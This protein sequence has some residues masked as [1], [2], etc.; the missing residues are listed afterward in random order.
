MKF[1]LLDE[2][3][4]S[5]YNDNGL[6]LDEKIPVILKILR[7]DFLGWIL[8]K[9]LEIVSS[10]NI[11]NVVIYVV[12]YTVNHRRLRVYYN[13][14]T[15]FKSYDGN[16]L[17]TY[18]IVDDVDVMALYDG[19]I[20]NKLI[21]HEEKQKS[22]NI[23]WWKG[24]K[25]E[26]LQTFENFINEIDPYGEEDWGQDNKIYCIFINTISPKNFDSLII[27]KGEIID[28][29]NDD[30]GLVK[31]FSRYFFYGDTIDQYNRGIEEETF[32]LANYDFIKNIKGMFHISNKENLLWRIEES[33]VI[34]GWEETCSLEV[35]RMI[36]SHIKLIVDNR[37]YFNNFEMIWKKFENI[38]IKDID[39]YGEEDWK[40][41]EPIDLTI[42][43]GREKY[44]QLL[45]TLRGIVENEERE[46]EEE[47]LIN[48]IYTKMVVEDIYLNHNDELEDSDIIYDKQGQDT[49]RIVEIKYKNGE[50][51]FRGTSH[52]YINEDWYVIYTDYTLL[53]KQTL[54]LVEIG[55]EIKI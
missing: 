30:L 55:I 34:L 14:H 6:I 40:D 41:L 8:L 21:E 12:N 50:L 23:R 36:S 26:N 32:R 48:F 1:K 46:N 33:L 9:N 19:D 49:Q 39:P 17:E 24:G 7:A 22:I 15:S 18:D 3:K 54:F 2:I 43:K 38:N 11:E 10:G 4:L 16:I 13:K 5:D 31:S 52:K 51:I 47:I 45:K 37:G 27:V 25:F 53:P 44:E 42:Y 29:E 20:L 28:D 35:I